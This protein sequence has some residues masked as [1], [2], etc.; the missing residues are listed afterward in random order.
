M[1]NKI[2]ALSLVINRQWSIDNGLYFW[3]G[4]TGHTQQ[5]LL[6]KGFRS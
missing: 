6:L 4:L 5:T 2:I 1:S 3:S